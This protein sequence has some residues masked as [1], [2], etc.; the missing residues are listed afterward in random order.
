MIG[1]LKIQN[2]QHA[3]QRQPVADGC[4]D[5]QD[6]LGKCR[7]DPDMLGKIFAV[8]AGIELLQRLRSGKKF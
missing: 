1:L 3:H 6:L 4:R 5:R 7:I 8:A 2:A